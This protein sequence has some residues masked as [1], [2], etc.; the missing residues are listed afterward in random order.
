M[1]R[2]LGALADTD[3]EGFTRALGRLAY[4]DENAFTPE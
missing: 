2:H 4:G 1:P 3:P